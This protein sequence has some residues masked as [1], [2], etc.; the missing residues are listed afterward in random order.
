MEHNWGMS[1]LAERLGVEVPLVQAPMAGAGGVDLAVA[2]SRAGGLGSLPAAMLDLPTLTTQLGALREARVPYNLNFFAHTNP[3]AEPAVDARWHEV[4]APFACELGVDPAHL[5][6][7]AGRLPVDAAVLAAVELFAPRVVSFHFGLPSADLVA[8]VKDWGALVM[9]SATTVA[10]AVWLAQHGADVLIAQG[11]EAGG[12]RGHFLTEPHDVSGQL[13]TFALVPQ[14]V[15][16]VDL[17]VIAAGGI[18][19]PDGVRAALTLGAA[20][21]QAGTTYLRSPESLVSGLHRSAIASPEAQ[22]TVVTRVFSGRPARGIVNRAVRELGAMSPAAP[23]FPRAA[24]AW[25][26]IRAAAEARGSTDFTPLWC[27]QNPSG[28]R[29]LPAAEITEWLL[30]GFRPAGPRTTPAP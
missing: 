12:H 2:V 6:S 28:A 30:S 29:D 21:V 7:G 5:P 3:V 14:V 8:R 23:P 16:A 18:A 22:N 26:P 20:G 4:L 11:W 25:G 27:G 24:P 1:S 13:G 10:E 9:C 15:E 17:P 19:S